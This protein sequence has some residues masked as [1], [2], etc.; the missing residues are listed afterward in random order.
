MTTHVFHR[1]LKGDLPLA[2][3]GDGPYII[4]QNGDAY[5]DASG[6][7]A[8]SCIGHSNERVRAAIHEQVDK[9]A[10]AHTGFFSSEPAEKLADFLIERAPGDMAAAYFVSGGSEA[11]ETAL[12][13]ARQYF[14][15]IDQPQ[16]EHIIARKQSYH[17]NTLGALAV[18]GNE[19]R[20]ASFAPLLINHGRVSACYPYRNQLEGETD[21][22]YGTR[23]A[24]EL[25]AEIQRLGEDK[26]MAFVAETVSGATLGA[27]QPVP[28]YLKKMREVCDRYGVLLILDEIM[29]GMGRTG[30][31]FA[32]EQDGVAPDL[33]TIAKGLGGGYQPIGAVLASRRVYNAFANGSGVFMNGHTYLGHP[34]ACAAAL[35]VQQVIEGDN[36]IAN[37]QKQGA[38]LEKRLQDAFGD[39]PNVG[40][41]RGRG[42]FRAIEFVE[43]RDSKKPFDPERKINLRLKKAAMARKM[44][45]Y[46]NG[47][48]I[49]GRLGDHV[50]LAPPFISDESL[51]D[52]IV[53]RLFASFEEAIG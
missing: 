12:K 42:L 40:D 43:D 26:V 53:A 8:V 11:V 39:H 28:G 32:C 48:T 5:I 29:C 24:A 6:G 14:L 7:A 13:M 23:L 45:C 52:E 36:L 35:A 33:V 46:P 50:L 44:V 51:I 16:R 37:V 31:L 30:S 21:E 25:E 27:Q 18:G 41:I 9:L 15:E 34:V 19:W 38:Y 22:A 49:D 3:K 1:S 10:Y 17:G 2:E 20:R 47:G 4:A